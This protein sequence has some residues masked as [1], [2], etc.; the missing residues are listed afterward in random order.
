MLKVTQIIKLTN[1]ILLA[2]YLL[3]LV[4]AKLQNIW[5]SLALIFLSV[6][7]FLRS[8]FFKID[9]RLYVGVLLLLCG[10]FGVLVNYYN[11]N[12]N[13]YYPT[14]IMIV[15]LASFFVFAFFR[16]KFHLKVFV[17]CLLEVLLLVVYKLLYISL[18]EFLLIELSLAIFII[19]NISK[20][21]F[22]NTRSNK[23]LTFLWQ[24]TDTIKKK[25][26]CI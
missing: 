9:S 7:C 2:L 20:R 19:A 10:I 15:G 13:V 22:I 4:F 17:I 23:W 21:I 12:L 26:S 16:Q 3:L 11:L 25:L 24:K 1:I 6:P 14:Y 8:Y 5:F 18:Q